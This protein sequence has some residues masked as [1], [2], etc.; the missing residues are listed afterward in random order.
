MI[1]RLSEKSCTPLGERFGFVKTSLVS[2]RLFYC[3]PVCAVS[4]LMWGLCS[5]IEMGHDFHGVPLINVSFNM[6][7]MFIL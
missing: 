6:R 7:E 4:F 3:G 1:Y 5:D 2:H